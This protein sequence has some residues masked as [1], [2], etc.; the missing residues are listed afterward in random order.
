MHDNNYLNKLGEF[1]LE[2]NPEIKLPEYT[3]KLE[4]Y[5]GDWKWVSENKLGT[6]I[7]I[8]NPVSDNID[9]LQNYTIIVD[10][11]YI[12]MD[13]EVTGRK[14]DVE[15][16]LTDK[17]QGGHLS[18]NLDK[19][20]VN[21]IE[22][23]TEF[24]S[25][26][27]EDS[28]SSIEEQI[29]IEYHTPNNV[30]LKRYISNWEIEKYTLND[31]IKKISNIYHI[32]DEE[33]KDKY[34]S[35]KNPEIKEPK[36][37]IFDNGG[38]T[39]DR[40]TIITDTGE[41]FGFDENPFNPN[42]FGQYSFNVKD[43]SNEDIN[44]VDKFIN[45][46][47][48]NPEWL[49]IEISIDE[50]PEEAQKY[51]KDITSIENPTYDESKS[52]KEFDHEN[53]SIPEEPE[54]LEIYIDNDSE[55]YRQYKWPIVQ[56]LKKHMDKGAFDKN[57]ALISFMRL[58]N[59]GAKKYIKEFG[60]ETDDWKVL[61]PFKFRED[62]AK[63]Y[64]EW[65]LNEYEINKFES[66]DKEN[67]SITEDK[68]DDY[69]SKTF[70][71]G[72]WEAVVRQMKDD[73]RWAI[74]A[75]KDE[76]WMMMASDMS[77]DM[78][79]KYINK[80]IEELS[81]ERYNYMKMRANARDNNG[82]PIDE[83][84]LKLWNSL[85]TDEIITESN[86]KEEIEDTIDKYSLLPD[87]DKKEFHGEFTN[88]MNLE[89]V[90]EEI[91]AMDSEE[92]DMIKSLVDLH[93]E[94]AKENEDFFESI[95]KENWEM[96]L[97]DIYD[98][99]FDRFISYSEMYG[100]F[101]RLNNSVNNKY[102]SPEDMWNEN[103]TVTGGVNA[104]DLTIISDTKKESSDQNDSPTSIKL[105]DALN[106]EVPDDSE[107]I[108][109]YIGSN[110]LDKYFTIIKINPVEWYTKKTIDNNGTTIQQSY[111]KY[112]KPNQK[113][114]VRS[115]MKNDKEISNSDYIIIS[116]NT[117]INGYH[118]LVAMAL[119]GITSANAIDINEDKESEEEI[120][121]PDLQ[122]LSIEKYGKNWQDLDMKELDDIYIKLGFNPNTGRK[123]KE[124]TNGD[125]EIGKKVLVS[126]QGNVGDATGE[127]TK[128]NS[129]GTYDIEILTDDDPYSGKGEIIKLYPEEFKLKES[130]EP[131]DNISFKDLMEIAEDVGNE[132]EI[133]GWLY[134]EF[135]Q[136]EF[137]EILKDFTYKEAREWMDDFFSKERK[138]IDDDLKNNS[139]YK[140]KGQI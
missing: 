139:E 86:S 118:R 116:G 68:V 54:Q 28:N 21:Y 50:L 32:S 102:E 46:A 55:L 114:L 53:Y 111:E 45:T 97:K 8:T 73:K 87:E 11:Y 115:Y 88:P 34:N 19:D 70:D 96:K 23:V 127:I 43:S 57:K 42:G 27:F 22:L 44:T 92:F 29:K 91:Y 82:N 90:K 101:D 121:E 66:L 52:L 123:I 109:N 16:L 81:I 1:I 5:D 9:K 93:Y 134:Q 31:I 105:I 75:S 59:A 6:I 12:P 61:F 56:N 30:E 77:K 95:K 4:I 14:N 37:T 126:Y 49:G 26:Y 62:T 106:N 40:Y 24:L 18:L 3:F 125:L 48:D 140:Q 67:N 113:N 133:D 39:Q 120:Y 35:I 63:D 20:M 104:K 60:E 129:D 69:H 64:I 76:S 124:S 94:S 13:D 15:D 137:N 138:Y 71:K 135:L 83:P 25:K 112:A 41:V 100:I 131:T 136:K 47:L 85:A 130:I 78:M 2:K 117:L 51:V 79:N 10:G 58:V 107:K 119:K 103:P 89:K 110:D 7:I 108:W 74:E 36:F 132:W 98:D 65:F 72:V 84:A 80:S 99:N 122:K 33:A 17:I 38:E 128:I